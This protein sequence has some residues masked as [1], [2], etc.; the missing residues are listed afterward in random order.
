MPPVVA[1]LVVIGDAVTFALIG[2]IVGG[3]GT[4][5]LIGA[6][7]VAAGFAAMRALTPDIAMQQSDTDISRQQTVRG[8]V[9][10]QK[11]VYGE[12]L[13]SGPIFFVGVSGTENRDLYHGI[14]PKH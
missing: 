8:T 13:V 1:A 2:T 7:V 4:A 12:A 9:E 11:V 10:P 14:A 5:A 3:A 6:A